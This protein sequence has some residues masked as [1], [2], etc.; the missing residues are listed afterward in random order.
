[1]KKNLKSMVG[2][3]F[4]NCFL[5]LPG[6]VLAQSATPAPTTSNPTGLMGRLKSIAG[7]GGYQ[8]DPNIAS[9]PKIVGTVIGAFIGFLGITFLILIIYAG[10]KWMTAEGDLEDVKKA[11]Q[12]IKQ[13]TIGL[14]VTISAWS[15]W[16]FVFQRLILLSN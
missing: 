4:L 14:V 16:N 6:L 13:A 15:I 7:Q 10:F 11:K 1:M 3:L 9:T 5:L 12:T 8:T 2:L